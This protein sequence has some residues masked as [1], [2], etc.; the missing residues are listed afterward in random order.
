MSTLVDLLR[1]RR[2]DI[3]ERWILRMREAIAPRSLDRGDLI[4]SLEE[5]LVM[6]AD[7]LDHELEGRPRVSSHA[8]SIAAEH[9]RQRFE[10]GYDLAS[11]IREY[12]LLRDVLF[13][14][15]EESGAQRLD[16]RET[17]AMARCVFDVVAE[18]ATRY[19]AVRDDA[20]RRQ[21]EQHFGFLAHEL[22]NAMASAQLA[23]SVLHQTGAVTPSNRAGAALHRSLGNLRELIDGALVTYQLRSGLRATRA[24]VDLAPFLEDIV[25]DSSIEAESK[26][27]SLEV[28][29]P[30][31]VALEM[32]AKLIAS[33]A[34]NLVR[35]AIK[36][37]ARGGVVRVEAKERADGIVI[38]VEDSCGGL[39]L[40]TVEKLFDPFVQAGADRSGFGLGLAI[41]KQAVD[42]H[43]GALR[44]HDIPGKGCV[45]VM[46]LPKVAT[47]AASRVE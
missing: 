9:G 46:D 28:A 14:V 31:G 42:A 19:T 22:R 21:T 37:S 18:C 10:L 25:R 13:E 8:A 33:A 24:R 39:P 23:L 15:A 5:F 44:V 16:P 32:D 4:D 43:G 34:S 3:I 38:E 20:V 29:V 17:R 26:A 2:Q 12:G 11:T 40:G 1:D 27:V 47:T 6:L 30:G 7:E 35:N 45:F 41:A 36:F